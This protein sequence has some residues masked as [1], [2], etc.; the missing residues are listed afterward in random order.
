MKHCLTSKN[1]VYDELENPR[2]LTVICWRTVC[3]TLRWHG[4]IIRNLLIT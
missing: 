3:K 2:N 4:Q 1:M